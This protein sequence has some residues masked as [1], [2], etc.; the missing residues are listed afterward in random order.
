MYYIYILFSKK[1]K[2]LYIGFTPNLKLRI[3][4]H[5][6]GFVVSTKDRRPLKLIYYEAYYNQSDAKRREKFLKGGKGHNEL[7]TQLKE[8]FKKINYKFRF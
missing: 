6:K 8:V 3:E 5:N 7:K 4:K 1:D 2:K